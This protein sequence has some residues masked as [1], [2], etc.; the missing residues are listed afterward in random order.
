MAIWDSRGRG[1]GVGSS[2]GVFVNW[3]YFHSE[4]GVLSGGIS[5][6]LHVEE[7]E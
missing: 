1:Y 4:G 3:Q 5:R 2:Q 6:L 7:A